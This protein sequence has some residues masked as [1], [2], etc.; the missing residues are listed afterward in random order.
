MERACSGPRITPRPHGA[1]ALSISTAGQGAG[2]RGPTDTPTSTVGERGGDWDSSWN[3]GTT[4]TPSCKPGRAGQVPS[5]LQRQDVPVFPRGGW[6]CQVCPPRPDPHPGLWGQRPRLMTPGAGEAMETLPWGGAQGVTGSP[7]P[8]AGRQDSQA[9]SA[10]GPTPSGPSCGA[11]HPSTA[12]E[13]GHPTAHVTNKG[14]RLTDGV[15]LPSHGWWAV[16][17]GLGLPGAWVQG[18][19]GTRPAAPRGQRELAMPLMRTLPLSPPPSR[20]PSLGHHVAGTRHLE[21]A[22]SGRGALSS[23]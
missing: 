13:R 15:H 17:Q 20:F 18:G 10:P 6:H 16:L 19:G 5:H 9:P 14:R 3:C 23:R 2:G 21:R 8:H 4:M 1:T 11:L 7:E 22:P 12:S